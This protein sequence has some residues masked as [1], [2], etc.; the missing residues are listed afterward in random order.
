MSENI[1]EDKCLVVQKDLEI[2]DFKDETILENLVKI[3][4]Q[5][6]NNQDNYIS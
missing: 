2:Y 3:H 6:S 4:G 1:E 5:E